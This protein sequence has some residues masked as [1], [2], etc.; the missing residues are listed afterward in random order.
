MLGVLAFFYVNDIII[1]NLL[2]KREAAAKL[3]KQLM[4][5]FEM[6]D[7]GTNHGSWVSASPAT[8]QADHCMQYLERTKLL[9]GRALT[10]NLAMTTVH[11]NRASGA[12]RAFRR[13]VPPGRGTRSP[14]SSHVSTLLFVSGMLSPQSTC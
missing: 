5:R 3:K 1:M 10:H 11:V 6:R 12:S 14:R 13:V 2:D 4:A 9:S 8:A 7:L